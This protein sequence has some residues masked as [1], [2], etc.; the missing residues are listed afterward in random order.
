MDSIV[1]INKNGLMLYLKL[2]SC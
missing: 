1:G 2:V